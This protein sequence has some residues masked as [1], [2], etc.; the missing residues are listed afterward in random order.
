[1]KSTICFIV[2]L[3][4]CTAM[5]TYPRRYKPTGERYTGNDGARYGHDH[6]DYNGVRSNEKLDAEVDGWAQENTR[7]K[8]IIMIKQSLF[9]L[10]CFFQYLL[11]FSYFYYS[12]VYLCSGNH[13]SVS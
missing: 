4:V 6:V 3:L 12:A 11:N 1:M 2:V 13:L 10:F 9:Q 5:A 7:A 8:G